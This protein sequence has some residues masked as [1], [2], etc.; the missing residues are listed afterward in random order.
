[1]RPV[2][3]RD[4]I[5]IGQVSSRCEHTCSCRVAFDDL[6]EMVSYDM[7]ILQPRTVNAQTYTLPEVGEHVL[8]AFLPT[9]IEEGYILGS[10]YTARNMP[11]KQ[12]AGIYYTKYEDGTLIEYNLN[13]H[14]A[15]IISEYYV[16][17]ECKG[18]K[19]TAE[20][21]DIK[22][23]TVNIEAAN[24]NIKGDV[25]VDGNI[26]ATGIIFDVAGNSNHH[27]HP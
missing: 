21:I 16:E 20:T 4:V 13:T 11:P 1:M 10:F 18:A 12:E 9:G 24:V 7:Q 22:A 17:V 19:V 27:G 5:R 6:D 3:L 8:C 15:R 14:T 23:T 26:N 2:K 25:A